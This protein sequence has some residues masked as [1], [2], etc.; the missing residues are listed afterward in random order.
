MLTF[1]HSNLT[2]GA[3]SARHVNLP[4]TP[5]LLAA[6]PNSLDLSISGWTA[7]K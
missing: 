7:N 3:P 4:V 1:L 6:L 5:V 2:E